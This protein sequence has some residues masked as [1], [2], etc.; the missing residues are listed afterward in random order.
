MKLLIIWGVC[1]MIFAVMIKRYGQRLDYQSIVSEHSQ[2]EESLGCNRPQVRW[3]STNLS[4][5]SDCM[6]VPLLNDLNRK[7]LLMH[8]KSRALYSVNAGQEI[9]Y[10]RDR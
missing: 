1:A 6:L 3:K 10:W 9:P 7:R 2:R 4:V 5:Y 8:L